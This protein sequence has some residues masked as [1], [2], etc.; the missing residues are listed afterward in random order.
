MAEAIRTRLIAEE[1]S[2]AAARLA[3][4]GSMRDPDISAW[5]I[6]NVAPLLDIHEPRAENERQELEALIIDAVETSSLRAHIG[7]DRLS[8]IIATIRQ[9]DFFGHLTQDRLA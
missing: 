9:S 8:P 7:D 5:I 2:A 3:R 4:S 1:A 6:D